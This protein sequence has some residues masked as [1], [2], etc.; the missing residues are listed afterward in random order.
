MS[1]KENNAVTK[2]LLNPKDLAEYLS[3]P[4]GSLYVKVC[5][6]EI[7]ANCYFKIGRSLKFEKV[8]IDAWLDSLKTTDTNFTHKA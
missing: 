8:A 5:K 3:I 1:N 7:P 2:R 4:V 6:K